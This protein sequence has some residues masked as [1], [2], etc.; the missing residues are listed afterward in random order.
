VP[1]AAAKDPNAGRDYLC[2][3]GEGRLHVGDGARILKRDSK[4]VLPAHDGVYMAVEEARDGSSPAE[5]DHQRARPGEVRG[6][7]AEGEDA[8]ICD[9]NGVGF[10]RLRV[11]RY[12]LSVLQNR[13]GHDHRRAPLETWLGG[14]RQLISVHRCRKVHQARHGWADLGHPHVITSSGETADVRHKSDTMKG[15]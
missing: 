11:E 7:P 9:R 13:L 3:C 12:H 6:I 14:L 5:V 1:A 2:A 10:C 8:P 4:L 15:K